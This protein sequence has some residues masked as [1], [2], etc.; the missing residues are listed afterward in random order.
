[1]TLRNTM[2]LASLALSGLFLLGC[3]PERLDP[4]AAAAAET[5]ET[6]PAPVAQDTVKLPET[7]FYAIETPMGRMV[8]RLY[9]ETPLHRDNFKRLAADSA[10]DGTTFHRIIQ[11]F[12]IQGGDPNSRDDDPYND[13]MGDPGYT[14]PAEIRPARYHKRGALAAARQGDPVNPERRSAGHPRPGLR[15]LGGGAGDLPDGGRR[16]LPGPAVHRLRRA[17][18]GLR[19]ARPHR[20]RGDAEEHGDAGAPPARR[21]PPR[22]HPD[23]DPPPAR[24]P[25]PVTGGT[26]PIL[27]GCACAN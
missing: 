20:R 22:S 18:R 6:A 25:D 19:R 21:P 15:F 2:I 14:V 7:N 10:Y 26:L 16:T 23:D 3:S 27:T 13:G 1:M 24:L 12:M 4:P 8:V 17:R 9:D 11:G 5:A